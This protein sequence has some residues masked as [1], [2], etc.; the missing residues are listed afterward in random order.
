MRERERERE[1][2]R[3]RKKERE[4]ERKRER[5]RDRE[6][7]GV[8]EGGRQGEEEGGREIF[9]NKKQINKSTV[10]V[11]TVAWHVSANV[12][13]CRLLHRYCYEPLRY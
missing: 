2:K 3:E 9:F 7:L 11:D 8:R 1:R 10:A 12:G 6:G 4:R 5:E 13:S